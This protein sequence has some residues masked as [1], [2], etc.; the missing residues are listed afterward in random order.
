ML[1][2]YKGQDKTT[3]IVNLNIYAVNYN[4]LRVMSGLAALAYTL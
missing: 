3:N 2:R 4:I 1:H